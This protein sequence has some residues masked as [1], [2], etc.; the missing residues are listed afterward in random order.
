GT[1]YSGTQPIPNT[2]G[3]LTMAGSVSAPTTQN[4]VGGTV[5]QGNIIAHNGGVGIGLLDV[6]G[7]TWGNT[8]TGNSIFANNNPTNPAGGLGIELSPTDSVSLNDPGDAD[9]GANNLQ[10]FPVLTSAYW[11]AGT[12]TVSG[13]L[14][15]VPSTTAYRL[16]VYA[17]DEC[18]VSGYGEGQTPLGSANVTVSGI[19]DTPFNLTL[20]VTVTASKFITATATAPDGSTSEFSACISVR[21]GLTLNVNTTDDHGEVICTMDHCTLAEAIAAADATGGIKETIAFNLPGSGPFSIKPT[22]LLPDITDPVIIDGTSQPGYAGK[23]IVELNG[24]QVDGYYPWGLMVRAGNSTIRGLVINGWGSAAIWLSQGGGNSILGNYLGTNIQGNAAVPNASGIDIDGSDA[25]FI[26]DGTP[27]GRNIISGNHTI[28]L[29][30]SGNNNR[31]VGNFIGVAADGSPFNSTLV[32]LDIGGD[33]ANPIT[34]TIIEGN[35]IASILGPGIGVGGSFTQGVTIT[36]N[37]IYG[38]QHATLPDY[39]PGIDLLPEGTTLNDAGDA[40]TGPNNLQNFPMLT[41]AET[42]ASNLVVSGTLDT[43]PAATA[44]RLDFYAN[45]ECDVSGYGEGQTPL[46]NTNVT[47]SASGDTP[48]NLTLPVTVA[49]G[50][51]ITATATAP[52]GS[53]SEFSACVPVVSG[54]PVIPTPI[55]LQP[56]D[57]T[58]MANRQPTFQWEVVPDVTGYEI[59]LGRDNPPTQSVTVSSNSYIPASP[60]LY[61]TYYW[62]VRASGSGDEG[63]SLVWSV[64]ITAPANAAPELNLVTTGTPTL[65]WGAVRWA[66]GYELV[67]DTDKQFIAPVSYTTTLTGNVTSAIVQPPQS[68]TDGVYYWRVRAVA[69]GRIGAWSSPEAFTVDVP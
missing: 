6:D 63:W 23:P 33:Q 17:N 3:G 20:P 60:L 42:Q 47:I 55:L 25:N 50:K 64:T 46:G 69:P 30:I 27:A 65:T 13:R 49:A 53:T 44:Y 14:D 2:G 59:Q 10:N 24:S 16:D 61:D 1:D 26:G 51:F 67:V 48:F 57:N 45:D 54:I 41:S 32:G 40:D 22:S 21:T 38:N 18:D 15:T 9:T 4:Q 68:L 7:N 36:G 5:D 11:A 37:A 62:R 8:I 39:G 56:T 35:T 66:T 34:S 12:V 58:A 29:S 28:G 43:V 31:I 52:D 19:G